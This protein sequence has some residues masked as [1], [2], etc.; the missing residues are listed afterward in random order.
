MPDP[1]APQKFIRKSVVV[2]IGDTVSLFFPIPVRFTDQHPADQGQAGIR[3]EILNRRDQC[4]RSGLRLQTAHVTLREFLRETQ[5]T[6]PV[7][8]QMVKD[9]EELCHRTCLPDGNLQHS[10]FEKVPVTAGQLTVFF[11]NLGSGKRA[12]R[13]VIPPAF[14]AKFHLRPVRGTVIICILGFC[15]SEQR[16]QKGMRCSQ[17]LH[18]IPYRGFVIWTVD[19][20]CDPEAHIGAHQVRALCVNALHG[21]PAPISQTPR[22][23]ARLTHV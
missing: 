23:Y 2:S 20:H 16:I 12:F 3:R 21:I 6:S 9:E 15:I 4:F 11:H 18:R 17:T 10:L 13:C 22:Q 7:R 5:R 1:I 8:Q 14:Q 19:R